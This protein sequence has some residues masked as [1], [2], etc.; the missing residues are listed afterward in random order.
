[1]WIDVPSR[2]KHYQAKGIKFVFKYDSVAPDLLHIYARHLTTPQVAVETFFSGQAT[3]N[4]GA[5]RFETYSTTHGLLWFWLKENEKVMVI[6][7]FRI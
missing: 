7:C 2:F 5:K 3:W 6:S 1:V 4:E